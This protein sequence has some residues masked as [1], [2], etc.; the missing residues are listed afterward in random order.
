MM[1]H[2]GDGR[3]R[4]HFWTYMGW[5]KERKVEYAYCDLCKKY[6]TINGKPVSKK[7]YLDRLNK[8]FIEGLM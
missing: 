6:Q 1:F 2:R 3:K 4:E 8:G 5:D 7:E